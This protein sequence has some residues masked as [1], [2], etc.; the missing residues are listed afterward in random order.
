MEQRTHE[1]IAA[2]LCGTPLAISEGRA[3]VA[4]DVS[5][6]MAADGEDQRHDRREQQGRQHDG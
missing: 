3:R 2:H 4:L 5:A 1:K 6:E